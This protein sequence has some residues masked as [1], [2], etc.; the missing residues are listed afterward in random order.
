M[1][2]VAVTYSSIQNANDLLVY[3]TNFALESFSN[4]GNT[5]LH[6]G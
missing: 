5:S 4:P 1:G 2:P 6:L 3:A